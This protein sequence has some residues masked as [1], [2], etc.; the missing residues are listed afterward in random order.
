MGQKIDDDYLNITMNEEFTKLH[1]ILSKFETCNHTDSDQ[2]TF[3]KIMILKLYQI[4]V[5]TRSVLK[6]HKNSDLRSDQDH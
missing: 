2:A 6:D 4:M 5:G 3:W 1:C